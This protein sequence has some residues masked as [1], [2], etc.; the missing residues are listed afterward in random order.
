MSFQKQKYRRK[1]RSRCLWRNIETEMQKQQKSSEKEE[2]ISL[3]NQR[4][5]NTAGE[6]GGG[7]FREMGVVAH[8]L[9]NVESMQLLPIIYIF[10][11]MHVLCVFKCLFVLELLLGKVYVRQGQVLNLDISFIA[12]KFFFR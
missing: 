10:N 8:I 4:N 6:G 3:E 9:H 7:A 1:R 2:Q 12:R 11:K 5:R